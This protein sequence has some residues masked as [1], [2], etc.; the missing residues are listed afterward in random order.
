MTSDDAVAHPE[1]IL[2]P[3]LGTAY[4]LGLETGIILN[5]FYRFWKDSSNTSKWIRLVVLLETVFAVYAF[6]SI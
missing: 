5:L 6:P 2:G 3:R 4:C 1:A